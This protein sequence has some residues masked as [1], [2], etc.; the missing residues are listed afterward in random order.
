M[1]NAALTAIRVDAYW[2]SESGIVIAGFGNAQS[3]PSL[4]SYVLDSIISGRLRIMEDKHRRT[5]I[6][7]DHRAAV[8]A[9][10]QSEMVSLF[11]DGIDSDFGTFITSFVAHSFLAKYPEFVLQLFD[12]YVPSRSRRRSLKQ[13]GAIGNKLVSAFAQGMAEYTREMHSSPIVEIVAHLPKEE[14]AAMAEALVNLT[15]FKRHVTREAETVGGPIDVAVISKGDGLIWIKRKHYF[16]S[17]L[18]PQFLSNYY[19]EGNG[20]TRP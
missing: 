9:F 7:T 12:K 19:R 18:N 17:A 5:D 4:R 8:S 3:F 10:A 14:L 11:M 6:T 20:G 2:H 16:E 13:L 1:L 15:S